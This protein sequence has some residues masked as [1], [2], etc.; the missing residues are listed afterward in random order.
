MSATDI[1]NGNT[2]GITTQHPFQFELHSPDFSAPDH[3]VIA[4]REKIEHRLRKFER[5]ILGVVVHLRDLNGPKGG[6]GMACHIEARL[7]HLEPV[8]VEEHEHDL[9]AAIDTAVD[10]IEGAIS[11]HVDRAFKHPRD[12]GKLAQ[13]SKVSE[14]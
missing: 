9:Y 14:G 12:R 3:L 4:V 1:G 6:V 2:N 10:R 11:R 8:N 13:K 7:P 5:H